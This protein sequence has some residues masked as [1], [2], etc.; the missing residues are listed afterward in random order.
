MSTEEYLKRI[1]LT[2]G[3]V[4]VL[5]T[6]VTFIWV[7]ADVLL[8]VFLGILLAIALRTLA[9]PIARRTRIPPRG[10]L[11]IVLFTILVL[12][13]GGGW[14]FVPELLRQTDQLFEQINAALNYVE[15]FINQDW[16]EGLAGRV[17]EGE[18]TL[19][20]FNLL[21]GL[22]GTFADT[23]GILANVLFIVFIGIFIAFD[24]GLY[25]TGII[26]LIPPT[27][28]QRAHEVIDSLIDGMQAWLLG[29]VISMI[30]IGIVVGVGL[31]LLG[32]PLA[33]ALGVLT[34]LLEFIPIVGPVFSAF[35]AILIAFTQD[36]MQA[37]YVAI[38]FLVAQQLEG[39]VL[40]PIVQ[41]K[42]VSLPPAL[43]LTAVLVMGFLFGPLG[44][45]VATPLAAA[46]LILVKMLY[47]EDVLGKK[48]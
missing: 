9:Y 2:A 18:Q 45:L 7:V 21:T 8:L 44:V 31:S 22:P 3:V 4:G 34:G 19:P 40:T 28:R 33:P 13:V 47:I 41:Q 36:I 25:R 38:F 6:L 37:V 12:M 39:N 29:R 1:L 32:I 15:A 30:V 16:G 35:P 20:D 23:L 48:K 42:T 26:S 24:P 14:L 46:I 5:I 11:L 10:A 27:G 17:F 43:T